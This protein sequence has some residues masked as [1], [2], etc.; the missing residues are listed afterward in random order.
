MWFE[1]KG[2]GHD[3]YLITARSKGVTC[4]RIL[5][6]KFE[7]AFLSFI[8]DLDW[9]SVIDE[10]RDGRLTQKLSERSILAD[11]L[12]TLRNQISGKER[13]MDVLTEPGDITVAIRSIARLET[14]ASDTERA[15]H[16]LDIDID[17]L[18][19]QEATI[20][21][22][23]GL[24]DLLKQTNNVD[25]RLRLR[26]EIAK[27]I[28]C[29]DV[30]W[31]DDFILVFIRFSNGANRCAIISNDSVSIYPRTYQADAKTAGNRPPRRLS[32]E[33]IEGLEK[34]GTERAQRILDIE[35]Q[36]EAKERDL[37]ALTQAS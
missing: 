1:R 26:A 25:V 30:V 18:K 6:S 17:G 31:R 3:A 8:R 16:V 37:E 33:E 4:H 27:R 2:K 14:E 10:K 32:Q 19:S 15:L 34:S 20:G 23:R 12:A 29:I 22:P 21:D 5:Y 13:A 7:T 36:I 28:Q 24:L 11:R 35:R 9:Q